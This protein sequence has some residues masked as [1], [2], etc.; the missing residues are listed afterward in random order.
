MNTN[1]KVT[2]VLPGLLAVLL[3]GGNLAAAIDKAADECDCPRCSARRAARA[4]EASPAPEPEATE[5]KQE[6]W[7]DRA[8]VEQSELN[9]RISR[10]RAFS[11]GPG[12]ALLSGRQQDLLFAQLGAMQLY[13]DILARRIS[14]S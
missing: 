8:L 2:S 11:D 1:G 3:S 12:L 14:A 6:T 13:A 5:G 9:E 7:L 4:A 10:L